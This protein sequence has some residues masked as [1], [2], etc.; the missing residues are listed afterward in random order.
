MGETYL[1][2]LRSEVNERQQD[3]NAT[4]VAIERYAE[5]HRIEGSGLRSS[6]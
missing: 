6:G 5:L 1:D 3:L 4:L 2:D